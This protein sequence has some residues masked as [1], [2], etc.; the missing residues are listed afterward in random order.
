ML[1][2]R[3]VS[4][5]AR[6]EMVGEAY[7]RVTADTTQMRRALHR[8]ARDSERDMQAFQALIDDVADSQISAVKK[9]LASG[10]VDPKILTRWSKEFKN[11]SEAAGELPRCHQLHPQR[12]QRDDGQAAEGTP[13]CDQPLG[14]AGQGRGEPCCRR[15][16][17]AHRREGRLDAAKTGPPSSSGCWWQ[18]KFAEEGC[19]QLADR[20]G[21][22]SPGGIGDGTCLRGLSPRRDGSADRVARDAIV[23]ADGMNKAFD[24]IVCE[25]AHFARLPQEVRWVHSRGANSPSAAQFWSMPVASA[26]PCLRRQVSCPLHRGRAPLTPLPSGINRQRG[27][28][29]GRRS[30]ARQPQ[31]LQLRQRRWRTRQHALRTL[32][33][34]VEVGWWGQ[35]T[36]RRLQGAEAGRS[37]DDEALSALAARAAPAA[38]AGLAALAVA[39]SAAA[40]ALPILVS[41]LWLLIGALT[42]LV[43]SISIGIVGGLLALGPAIAGLAAGLGAAFLVFQRMGKEGTKA[44]AS[45]DRIKKAFADLGDSA[46]ESPTASPPRSKTPSSLRSMGRSR[47]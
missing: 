23:H 3:R 34:H 21:Q 12:L 42:A 18:Q 27:G 38:V 10:L 2:K 25:V 33:A 7:V 16:A 37:L 5:V 36:R 8:A 40:V 15:E 24:P 44:A 31:Q 9:R 17:T 41:G 14:E 29:V 22:T 47:S 46:S 28:S 4:S 20:C 19:R 1:S 6:G 30:S 45:L 11:S 13:C 26:S 39:V 35:S 32:H 43:G